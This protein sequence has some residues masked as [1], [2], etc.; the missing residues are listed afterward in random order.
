MNVR[1][2]LAFGASLVLLAGLVGC[3][4][5]P[6]KK[7]VDVPLPAPTPATAP[8]V[9]APP[10]MP[11]P[12]KLTAE[13]KRALVE[14]GQ[15]A[16]LDGDLSMA[17]RRFRDAVDMAPDLVEARY[18]LGV[19]A[20]WQGRYTEARR[21]Y[22]RAL[23][24]EPEFAAAVVAIGRLMM[25]TG[26]TDSALDFARDA[27]SDRPKSIPLRNALNRLRVA[28]RRELGA[29]ES[30]SKLVLREDEKNVE[31]MVNLATAFYHAKKYELAIA[32]LQNAKV[33]DEQNPEILSRIA[34]AH[35]GLGEEL[36]ARIALEAAAQLDGGA[37]AEVYNNL[38]LLYHQAGDYTSAE[39]QFRKALARWPDMLSARINLGN[40]LKGQQRYIDAD[41]ELRTALRTSPESSELLF[42]LGILYLDGTLPS[43]GPID[44]LKQALKFF[45]RYKEVAGQRAADDPTDAYIGETN[46]RIVVEQKKAEQRRKSSKPAP[47]PAPAPEDEAPSDEETQ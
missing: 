32:I 36:Q 8:K 33:L 5:A 40:A 42:N 25:R 15:Q 2:L 43:V 7:K 28:A 38:G 47:A 20:E 4:G 21:Q 45:E 23:A 44:R 1:S 31:A 10:P 35:L 11:A 3:G 26:D 37:T 30:E 6:K 39:L 24:R 12:P 16:S 9:V 22:E 41:Q 34:L 19:L 29:V 27:L 18:N 14:A 46:K 13:E 17:E